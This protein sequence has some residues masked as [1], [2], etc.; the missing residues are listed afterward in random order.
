MELRVVLVRRVSAVRQERQD[1]AACRGLSDQVVLLETL[2]SPGRWVLRVLL[3]RQVWAESRDSRDG[4]ESRVRREKPE[5][6]EFQ[7]SWEV[8]AS[9]V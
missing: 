4:L 9:R 8:L 1:Q 6:Q 2:G 5:Y 7:D 3:V